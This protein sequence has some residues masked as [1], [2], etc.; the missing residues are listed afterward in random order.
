[1][2]IR[3]RPNTLIEFEAQ[4]QLVISA[5]ILTADYTADRP[6]P[7]FSHRL[8]LFPLLLPLSLNKGAVEV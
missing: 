1:M 8:S 6:K 5:S 7:S 2:L 3:L 4:V